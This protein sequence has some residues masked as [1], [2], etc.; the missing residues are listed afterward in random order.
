L[1]VA[2]YQSFPGL[3]KDFEVIDTPRRVIVLED[4]ENIRE[5][6]LD[7][8]WEERYLDNLDDERRMYSTV[9]RES[10]RR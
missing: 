10:D 2:E 7:E 4:D 3:A 9:L 5:C 1:A 8:D 6:A